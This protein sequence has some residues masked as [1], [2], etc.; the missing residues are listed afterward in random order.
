MG[1]SGVGKTYYMHEKLEKI[2]NKKPI[3]II[4]RS[5]NEYRNYKTSN[6]IKPINFFKGS[7]V[8]V[9]DMLGARN[10]SLADEFYTRVKVKI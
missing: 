1:P 6:E 10:D 2:S 3:H 5:P 8:I 7:Y 4:T 9:D